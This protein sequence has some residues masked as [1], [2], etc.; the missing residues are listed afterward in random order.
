MREIKDFV[1]QANRDYLGEAEAFSTHEDEY[2]ETHFI[3]RMRH[4]RGVHYLDWIGGAFAAEPDEFGDEQP[5]PDLQWQSLRA[6]SGG[7]CVQ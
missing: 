4:G 5:F 1:E 2:G 3:L 6:G 7:P